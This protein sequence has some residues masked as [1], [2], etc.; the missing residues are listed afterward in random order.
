M[1]LFEKKKNTVI[2]KFKC[3]KQKHSTLVNRKNLRNKSDVLTRLHFSGR[4][5][6]SES[7]CH[8]NRQL[9]Y[10]NRQLENAGKIHSTW[11]LNNPVNVKPNERSQPTKIHHVVDIEKLS[12]VDNLDEFIN[13]TSF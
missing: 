10:K 1:S 5:F 8:E 6:V 12:G 13:K 2:V 9:S 4:L 7:M 11:F 3:R